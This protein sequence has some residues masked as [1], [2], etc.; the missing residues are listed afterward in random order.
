MGLR[1]IAIDLGMGK[2]DIC[3]SQGAELYVDCSPDNPIN[4]LE[5]IDEYTQGWS[6]MKSSIR[7][8]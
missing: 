1:P 3:I 2:K 7:G 6:Y 5:S 8:L 4:I